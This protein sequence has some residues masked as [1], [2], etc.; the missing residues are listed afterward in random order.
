MRLIIILLCFVAGI[1]GATNG[2]A[3]LVC[4][5]D[6]RSFTREGEFAFNF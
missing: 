6:S 1:H 3:N 4:Y 2:T 5:Y